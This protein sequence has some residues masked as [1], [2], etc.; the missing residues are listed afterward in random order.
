MMN[1]ACIRNNAETEATKALSAKAHAARCVAL[2][3]E[4]TDEAA[5]ALIAE[6]NRAL[7]AAGMPAGGLQISMAAYRA[8][9]PRA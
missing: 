4:T 3:G 7:S 1:P 6:C 8:A 2:R 9:W 5:D